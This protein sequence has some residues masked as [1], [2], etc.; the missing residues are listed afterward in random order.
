MMLEK[1][2]GPE[3]LKKLNPQER[4]EL[5]DE[6]RK[7]ML[8]RASV[9]MGHV[10]P[11]LGI[12]EATVALHTVFDSPKDK[13]VYDVSHQSYPHKMLTGRM[14]AYTDP[15][16]YN[17]VSGYTNPDESEH[18][19]FNVGHTS[20]SISLASGLAKARD[21]QGGKENIIAVIGDGSL[22]GG[23]AVEGLDTVGELGTNFIV[24]FNDNDMSIAEN[25]G[26][27]YKG[28]K[29]LRETNGQAAD[30]L[31]R[32]FGLDYRFVADGND[33]EALIRAFEEVRDI[34]HPVVVHIVTQKGKGYAPAEKNKEDWHWHMPFDLATGEVR[35]PYTDR[36]G[37]ATAAFLLQQMKK[38][39]KLVA[40]TAAVPMVMGFT[41]ERRKEAGSQYI[42]VGIAEEQAVSMAS[43]LAKGGMHPV[44]ASY[45]TF[46]QRTYDQLSQDVCVN[47]NPAT[48]L[49]FG[50][51]MYSMNDV[52]HLCFY[53]IPLLSNIPNLVYLAPA[54]L[55]EYKAML[56]W[57]IAQE[58]HPVAIRVPVPVYE[59]GSL[60][61][62]KA[63]KDYRELNRF[64]VTHKGSQ[65]ALLGAG[66]FYGLA[67]QTAK[68][69]QSRGIDAT[70]INPRYLTGLDTELLEELRKDHTVVATMEDGCLAGGFGEKI[71][72]YYGKTDM[73]ILN[74]GIPK[75]FYDRYDYAR[76][77]E[78][79][80]LTPQLAAEDIL[81]L[82]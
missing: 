13:I 35:E 82:L 19:F 47:R 49:V 65:V 23:M 11:D 57:A 53:D 67:E 42:D 79:N 32:A 71:A 29:K 50:A 25:H 70:V 43:G 72:S 18:D 31:F 76:L 37:E 66:N 10:G 8:E 61:P 63:E 26:G 78:E 24:V 52:T 7:A 44:F 3:D 22:S 69:L 68:E 12:V 5:I 27:M 51:S 4:Q 21:L 80:H 33:V 9:H 77:A 48:F 17:D 41:P 1:I 39:P 40:M 28:I 62:V 54:T 46:F 81:A 64:A 38:D 2:K 58:T 20:T 36:Y 45:A 16:H 75:A 60:Y 55:E 73:R 15:A 59:N 6:M 14:Q 74:F 30:N 56:G 34:D